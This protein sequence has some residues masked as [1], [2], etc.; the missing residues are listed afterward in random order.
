MLPFQFSSL[1]SDQEVV[2]GPGPFSSQ[3]EGIRA[4]PIPGV[5]C[6]TCAAD[7]REVWVIPGRQCGY[8]HTPAP[9][10]DSCDGDHDH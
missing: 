1:F 6:P 8:C 3:G 7:G 9:D 2:F 5:L 10:G 4:L